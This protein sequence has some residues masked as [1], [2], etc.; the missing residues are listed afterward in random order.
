MAV[1][2]KVTEEVMGVASGDGICDAVAF[3]GRGICY[4]RVTRDYGCEDMDGVD[5]ALHRTCVT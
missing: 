3:T 5:H 4:E 2:E 1:S